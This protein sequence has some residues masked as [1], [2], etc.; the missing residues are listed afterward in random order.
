MLELNIKCESIE[1]AQIY[2]NAHSYLHLLTD[3]H[4]ALRTARKHGS[5]ADV[6]KVFDNYMPELDRTVEHH[7]GAY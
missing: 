6:V 2:L 4:Q 5:P 7:T 1:D 3:L